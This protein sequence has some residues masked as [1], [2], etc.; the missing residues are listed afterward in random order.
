MQMFEDVL[1][2]LKK[3]SYSLSGI[4]SKTSQI[5]RLLSKS[6]TPGLGW[7]CSS[8]S[9]GDSSRRSM[10]AFRLARRPTSTTVPPRRAK[11][12][13]SR[14]TKPRFLS[15]KTGTSMSPES[16][17]SGKAMG[18]KTQ[19]RW[20]GLGPRRRWET[21]RDFTM[22]ESLARSRS[23]CGHMYYWWASLELMGGQRQDYR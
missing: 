5:A 17:V 2:S 21:W 22:R 8:F 11:T 7:F 13:R 18:G 16:S 10:A 6:W 20:S 23:Y 9:T 12:A 14:Y 15:S 1:S 19:E 4:G 3:K